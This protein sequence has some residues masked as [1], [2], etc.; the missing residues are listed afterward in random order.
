MNIMVATT[1]DGTNDEKLVLAQN[2]DFVIFLAHS[3]P[4]GFQC[5]L[6]IQG[7]KENSEE[8]T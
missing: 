2:L 3:S 5:F 8:D 4:A 6:H 1:L 7:V